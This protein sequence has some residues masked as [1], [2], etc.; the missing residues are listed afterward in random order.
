MKISGKLLLV[1]MLLSLGA[2]SLFAQTIPYTGI[3]VS[4]YVQVENEVSYTGNTY[5]LAPTNFYM[6]TAQSFAFA[7]N[8]SETGWSGNAVFSARAAFGALHTL[9]T[10]YASSGNKDVYQVTTFSQGY[11][12]FGDYLTVL[13]PRLTNGAPVAVRLTAS[14]DGAVSGLSGGNIYLQSLVAMIATTNGASVNARIEMYPI[15]N[16]M[17]LTSPIIYSSTNAT[18][19]V[20]DTY[21]IL[22]SLGA[23]LDFDTEFVNPA[24]EAT[25]LTGAI[26]VDATA[27]GTMLVS[28]S[29]HDYSMPSQ[30]NIT[31]SNAVLALSWPASATGFTL[32]TN[33]NLA[34]SN[35]NDYTGTV[36]TNAGSESATV[37]PRPGALFFRLGK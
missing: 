10:G 11:S 35:W 24:S 33:G 3:G 9:A 32:Q 29:G 25:D 15:T 17:T 34:T 8:V 21:Q 2:M 36:S 31:V 20:G 16:S 1:G 37:T 4:L 7:T 13:N 6:D 19:T 30:L 23:Q 22:C 27:P 12:G 26:Y 28:A 18:L 5:A 14:F